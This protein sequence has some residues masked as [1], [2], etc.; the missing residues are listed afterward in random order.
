MH[1]W[2]CIIKHFVRNLT[3]CVLPH[4]YLFQHDLVVKVKYVS[5]RLHRKSAESGAC[6]HAF[7]Q[8]TLLSKPASQVFSHFALTVTL[9][10]PLLIR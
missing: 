8:D 5:L 6:V 10:A 3:Q 7:L 4:L 2:N 9:G 1:S